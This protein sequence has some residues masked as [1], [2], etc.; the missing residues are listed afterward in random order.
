MKNKLPYEFDL[1]FDIK[2]IENLRRWV[3]NYNQTIKDKK[4]IDELCIKY[5]IKI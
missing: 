3:I 2:T 5:N 1:L 4:A